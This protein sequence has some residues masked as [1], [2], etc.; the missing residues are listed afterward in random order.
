VRAIKLNQTR[1]HRRSLLA[2]FGA[3]IL[4]VVSVGCAASAGNT[5]SENKTS[6][7]S[8]SIATAQNS[9]DGVADKKLNQSQQSTAVE[10]Q[11]ASQSEQSSKQVDVPEFTTEGKPTKTIET[12][13]GQKDIY[14]PTQDAEIRTY[15]YSS[16]NG[17]IESPTFHQRQ[18]IRQTIGM[19]MLKQHKDL[20]NNGCKNIKPNSHC[21]AQKSNK[22]F[23]SDTGVRYIC[24]SF[25]QD[26]SGKKSIILNGETYLENDFSFTGSLFRSSQ[27]SLEDIFEFQ[28]LNW[29]D[30]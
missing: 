3:T 13:W 4:A 8:T 19:A 22:V 12:P 24:T 10:S 1:Q 23:P 18:G 16:V 15:I 2:R 26:S 9:L 17:Y 25:D 30:K 6:P 20:L 5:S 28:C 11:S 21:L 7:E 27:F 14:D 29:E